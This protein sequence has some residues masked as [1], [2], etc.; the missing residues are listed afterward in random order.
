MKKRR[1]ETKDYCDRGTSGFSI[2]G[3]ILD[4]TSH[5]NITKLII[6]LVIFIMIQSRYC[7]HS[8]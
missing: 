2:R 3:G 7:E 5:I 8:C 1:E 4:V 6:I